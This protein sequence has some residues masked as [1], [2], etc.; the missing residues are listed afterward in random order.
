MLKQKVQ[1]SVAACVAADAAL[2]LEDQ[3]LHNHDTS[4]TV[5]DQTA[6]MVNTGKRQCADR[7]TDRDRDPDRDADHDPGTDPGARDGTEASTSAMIADIDAPKAPLAI[8]DGCKSDPDPAGATNSPVRIVNVD[9][10]AE[11][12]TLQNVSDKA[13]SV[14]DWNMCSLAT[15]QTMQTAFFRD[16]QLVNLAPRSWSPAGMTARGTTVRCITR[17]SGSYRADE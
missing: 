11:I 5:Y 13:V 6:P 9:K 7:N 16:S 14:E 2:A 8:D 1:L 17:L 3:T 12:V 10:V 15:N 4:Q